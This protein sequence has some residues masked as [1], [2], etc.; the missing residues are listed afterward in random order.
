MDVLS[1][2]WLFCQGDDLLYFL[3]LYD[4]TFILR[5]LAYNGSI[6]AGLNNTRV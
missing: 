6:F 5:L 3:Q 1:L 4:N 2:F